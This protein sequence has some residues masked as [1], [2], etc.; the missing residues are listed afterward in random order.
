MFEL[1]KRYKIET[2]DSIF[3]T[4]FVAEQDETH[5][6]IITERQEKVILLKADVKRCMELEL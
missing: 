1:E 6:K 5:I 3:Y 4:G 2:K